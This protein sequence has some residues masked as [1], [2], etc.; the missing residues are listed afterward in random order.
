VK[1]VVDRGR[2]SI[3]DLNDGRELFRCHQYFI[4]VKEYASK[5]DSAAG[6]KGIMCDIKRKEKS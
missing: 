1:V 5:V 6:R 4:L 2:I 3:I